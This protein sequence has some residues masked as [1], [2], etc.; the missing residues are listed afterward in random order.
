MERLIWFANPDFVNIGADS[1]NNG[2]PEPSKEKVLE[3]ID[4]LNEFT[5]VRNKKNLKRILR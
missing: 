3:L 5:E 2:L 4:R 1:K